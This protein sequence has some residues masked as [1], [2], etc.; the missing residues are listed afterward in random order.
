MKII[1]KDCGGEVSVLCLTSLPPQY[2]FQ[3]GKCGKKKHEKPVESE[4]VIDLN[5]EAL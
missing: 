5:E 4:I 3:C 2:I 1:C